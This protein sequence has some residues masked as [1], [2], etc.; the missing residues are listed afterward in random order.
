LKQQQDHN[1][2][3]AVQQQAPCTSGAPLPHLQRLLRGRRRSDCTRG[4][5]IML[6]KS[7]LGPPGRGVRDIQRQWGISWVRDSMHQSE[8]SK[9]RPIPGGP[10]MITIQY[11]AP[12]HPL[13]LR[14]AL[15]LVTSLKGIM[16]RRNPPPPTHLSA[17]LR[18]VM[19]NPCR[20]QYCLRAGAAWAQDSLFAMRAFHL[21]R[22]GMR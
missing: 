19:P 17:E 14:Q 1:R 18:L 4:G 16:I 21:V 22:D 2:V 5:V 6:L 7:A 12:T 20:P 10:T 3:T 11:V 8:A 13:K 15:Y 9:A